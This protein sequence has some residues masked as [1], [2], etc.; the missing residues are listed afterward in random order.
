MINTAKLKSVRKAIRLL[1][2]P[3]KKCAICPRKCGVNRLE[4]EKGYCR[5]PLKAAVYSYLAHHGEE[6][7]LSGTKGSG[8]IFFSHCNMKCAYCQNYH[9]SQLDNGNEVEAGKLADIML[10]LQDMGCHNINLVSPTHFMPQILAALEGA[11][12]KGLEVPIVYNTGGYELADVIKLIAGV[13]DIYM[14]DMRYSD[15]APAKNYSDAVNY[16]QHNRSSVKEMRRQVGDLIRDNGG[17]AKRGLII[18]LLALPED[19]SGI[20]KTLRFIKDEISPDA[21]LSIM[22]QYYPAFKAC[23]YK[24]ISRGVTRDE[25]ENIVD[26]ARKLGLNNS[27]IQDA[28]AEFDA[29]FF[30]T[31]IKQR[32]D[33]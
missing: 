3:L 25:Y 27:W 24:E 20:K 11:L 19:I 10:Y 16:V 22:S 33:F 4:G 5:A 30:G 9:F 7:P 12:E 21:Y 31:N 2:Q 17:I 26:E 1:G 8:T 32:T 15:D 23:N 18:R 29:K 14:P 13:I 28:P 6:P